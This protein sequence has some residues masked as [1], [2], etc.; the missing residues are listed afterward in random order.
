LPA[1]VVSENYQWSDNF[2]Y[3]SGRHSFKFGGE[4][5]RRRY[6]VFQASSP[7]GDLNFGRVYTTNPAASAGTGEGIADLLLGVPQSSTIQILNGTRGLRRTEWAFYA[8]DNMKVSQRLTLNFGLRYEVFAGWPW[9]EVADRQA[10]FLPERGQVFL[11]GSPEVPYA[12]GTRTDRNNLSPRFG[13]AYTLTP[14]TVLRAG[15]GVFFNALPLSLDRSLASNPPFVGRLTYANDQFNYTGARRASQGFDRPSSFPAVGASLNAVR[16]D[17]TMPYVQQWNFNIQRQ[18]PGDVL[19][20]LAYVGT[21][22][23]KLLYFPDI[24]LPV[25]GSTAVASR[26]AY[27][28]FADIRYFTPESNSNYNGLQVSAEK[29]FSGG[30]SF[31]GSYTWSHAIDEDS[32]LFGS[33]QDPR[34]RRGDRASSNNDLRHRLVFSYNWELPVG[35]GRALLGNVSPATDRLLGG[36]QFNGITNLYSGFPFTPM[37]S[38]N[39][40][41]SPGSSQRAQYVA[42]CDPML[43]R[44]ERTLD[45]YF[46]TSCFTTPPQFV[47]GDVGRNI[48]TGPGTVQFDFST[49]KNIRLDSERRYFQLRGEFFN[50]LNTPQFNNPNTG[51]GSP[52]AGTIRSAGSV[53]TFSRTQ[54]QIQLALKFFF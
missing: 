40:L 1:I 28:A 8:Q 36:W 32:G 21:K 3:I 27:P 14:K 39:T 34:N 49:F 44:S 53:L 22:G 33:V 50:I 42:G 29:R 9:T 23:T 26:R 17:V 12:S 30:L 37:S 18:V 4:V 13:F 54:R 10:Q 43:S 35:R 41:N 2:S 11:V 31:Q 16:M 20:T 19:L 15:Y 24:N 7:R 46:N 45:R 48:M 6:N 5:Q 25:P 47:F 52:A 51:I 38:I